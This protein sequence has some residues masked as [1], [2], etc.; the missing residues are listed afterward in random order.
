LEFVVAADIIHTM[1]NFDLNNLLL[2]GLLV[3]IRIVIGYTLEKEII[4]Y[5]KEHPEEIIAEETG[6]KP[7][8]SRTKSK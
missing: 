6:R 5:E 2:L 8:I 4:T 3:A 7:R 1:I